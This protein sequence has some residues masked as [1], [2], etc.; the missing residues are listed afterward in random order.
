MYLI[1]GLICYIDFDKLIKDCVVCLFSVVK[2]GIRG[3]YFVWY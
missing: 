2:L 3:D 1:F